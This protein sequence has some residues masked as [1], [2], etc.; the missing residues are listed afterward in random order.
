M[1]TP[2]SFDVRR[3]SERH[4]SGFT[5]IELIVVLT[6]LAVAY[7]MA[8]PLLADL[9]GGPR[10]NRLVAEITSALRESQ[11]TAITESR[12]VDFALARDGHTW[13]TG[14]RRVDVADGLRLE[15]RSVGGRAYRTGGRL[16]FFPDGGSTGGVLT[17]FGDRRYRQIEVDW[18]T[19]RVT[20]KD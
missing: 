2:I 16:K 13:Q 17:L 15:L 6:V 4:E 8:T 20:V 7:A 9:L 19:G 14:D 18:L 1:I 3:R 12:T 10:L 11:A 5:I